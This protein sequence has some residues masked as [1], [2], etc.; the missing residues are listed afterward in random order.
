[1]SYTGYV[2]NNLDCDDSP[3]TGF[4]INPDG[5]EANDPVDNNCDGVVNDGP[6]AVG[7]YGP[8]GGIVFHVNGAN[9]LE[10]APADQDSGTGVVWGCYGTN[11]TSA[12]GSALGTCVQ[13]TADILAANCTETNTATM[14]VYE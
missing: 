6:F 12:S 10:A 14:P 3:A 4:D 7:D 5:T 8:A 11:I 13:N 9:G 2:T 1:T